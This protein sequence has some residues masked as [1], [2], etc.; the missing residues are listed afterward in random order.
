MTDISSQIK[1]LSEDLD[2]LQSALTVY[3]G[4]LI[5]KESVQQAKDMIEYY[6]NQTL[7]VRTAL[8]MLITKSCCSDAPSCHKDDGGLEDTKPFV[9]SPKVKTAEE[10]IP[11][12]SA[13]EVE[14]EIN[15]ESLGE[16]SPEDEGTI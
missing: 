3:E 15:V 9:S 5:K 13:E 16:G 12:P 7:R 1:I 6:R 4:M 11:K 8:L 14:E 2:R 10:S